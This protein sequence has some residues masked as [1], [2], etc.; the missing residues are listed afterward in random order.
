MRIY[1]L[2]EKFFISILLRDKSF[3]IRE[4]CYLCLFKQ[5]L[6]LENIIKGSWLSNRNNEHEKCCFILIQKNTIWL[7]FCLGLAKSSKRNVCQAIT[8]KSLGLNFVFSCYRFPFFAVLLVMGKKQIY[9]Y[10]VQKVSFYSSHI[11]NSQRFQ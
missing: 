7:I 4:N 9:F 10:V 2:F 5:N 1:K 8:Q 6:L 11:Q 3:L